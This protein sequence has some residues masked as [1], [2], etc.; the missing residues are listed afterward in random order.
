MPPRLKT[1]LA[2][3]AVL[4]AGAITLAPFATA[5]EPTGSGRVDCK[6]TSTADVRLRVDPDGEGRFDVSGVVFSDDEDV[7]SWRMLHNDD[8]S[9]KGEVQAK[10]ADR[11]FKIS[12]SMV[13]LD[14]P[15]DVVFRAVNQSTDEVCRAEVVVD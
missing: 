14:V 3:G 1:T 7:W 15:D 9:Y 6:G 11:S 4:G 5:G 2:L 8:V 12:R 10:D 13:D